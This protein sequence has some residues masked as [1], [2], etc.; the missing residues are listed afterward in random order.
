MT[1]GEARIYYPELDGLR[2]FAFLLVFIHHAPA[3]GPPP[4]GLLKDIG[5][6]GVDLFFALS[7]FL[8]V[9]ILA[10]E[11]RKTGT[12][13]VPK[14]YIRRGLR[15]WPLYFLFCVL[16]IM[17]SGGAWRGYLMSW[18]TLGLF[19][20]TDNVF[21]AVR[22]YC[23]IPDTAHLWTISYEEQFYLVIPVML[24][25]FFRGGRKRAAW[26]LAGS[27]ALFLGIRSLMIGAGVPHPAIWVLPVT[28]FESILL[29]IVVG[30]GGYDLLFRRIPLP[31]LLGSGLFLAWLMTRL[32]PIEADGWSVMASYALVGMGTS[33][34]VH[35]VFRAGTA[36]WL[37]WITARPLVY[38]GKISYGLYV[39]HLLAISK[40][41]R[42]IGHL[43][44]SAPP[45]G[46][47]LMEWCLAFAFTVGLAAVSY[48]L[49]ER[50]FL[51]L[52]KRFEVVHSRPA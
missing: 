24:L 37:R 36:P 51:R 7:A 41:H 34:V 13:S 43:F 11:Y 32:P 44:P 38:L 14:F 26:V 39:Y 23:Q 2:F 10:A 5:W 27:A 29:G 21:T 46:Q 25:F 15:I 40:G 45:A 47:N 49:L 6:I 8:F 42:I 4:L 18:R 30:L 19:T 52:K 50:P 33:L 17:L 31:L 3:L 9:Q 35:V 28:H 16:K 20:F 48:S 22:G 12:I 1:A